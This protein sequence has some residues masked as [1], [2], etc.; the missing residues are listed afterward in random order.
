MGKT[1]ELTKLR[2]AFDK[3]LGYDNTNLNN[4]LWNW[5]KE[6]AS[7]IA[8]LESNRFEKL[9]MPKIAEKLILTEVGGFRDLAYINEN[10]VRFS[11]ETE[12]DGEWEE[13]GSYFLDINALKKLF[14]YSQ[15]F[16][17]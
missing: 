1:M 8:E 2:I 7:Q 16:M 3:I 10:G 13:G 6:H 4:L 14:I 9:V 17:G 5:I 12:E 11:Y 15:R